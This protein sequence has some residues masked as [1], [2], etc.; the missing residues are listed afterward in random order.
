MAGCG[1]GRQ[2]AEGG[3]IR[4][5]A[6]LSD[7]LRHVRYLASIFPY[8]KMFPQ[9]A[10]QRHDKAFIEQLVR[11]IQNFKYIFYMPAQQTPVRARVTL[12]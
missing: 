7:S 11:L 10:V 9:Q 8:G 4:G 3:H 5:T 1:L 12:R 2:T 6:I